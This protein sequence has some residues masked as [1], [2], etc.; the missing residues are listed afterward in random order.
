LTPRNQ[1]RQERGRMDNPTCVY[2][3]EEITEE[4]IETNQGL[5]HADCA[6]EYGELFHIE[7]KE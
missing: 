3:G 7:E 5:M 2:C 1:K 4:P 6:A